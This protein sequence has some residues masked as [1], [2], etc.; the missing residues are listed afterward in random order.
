MLYATR[1]GRYNLRGYVGQGTTQI[2]AMPVVGKSR[3]LTSTLLDSP[4]GLKIPGIARIL[5]LRIFKL[6]WP[7]HAEEY[8]MKSW[9]GSAAS[10]AEHL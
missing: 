5:R 7:A 4:R 10:H 6:A 9:R 1:I 8:F 3:S 2:S